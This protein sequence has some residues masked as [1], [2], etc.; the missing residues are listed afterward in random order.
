[1]DRRRFLAWMGMTATSWEGMANPARDL[2]SELWAEDSVPQNP[3]PSSNERVLYLLTYD[4]GGLVLWGKEHFLQYLHSAIEWLKRYPSFKI[5]LDNEAWTYDEL[6]RIAPEVLE[7][8]R[9]YLKQYP[10]R[11]GIG[12]CTYGQP[13]AQFINEESN[14]RQIAY[15]LETDRRYFSIAPSIYLMSEHAMHSQIPQILNGFK[16]Q[17]AIMR[18]HYMMYGYNPAFDLP[19]GWWVGRDGSKIAAVP[20]YKGEGA[21]FGKT[22]IDNW[23]LTRYPSKE[24]QES[25]ADFKRKF[26]RIQPLLASRADDSGLRREELVREIEGEPGYQWILLEELRSLFPQPAEE[27][28]TAPD[29]FK[30]RM[31]WGYC[32]NEIWNQSREA[33]VAVLTA[34]RM[35]AA[36][37]WHGGESCEALLDQAWK[38]LLVAQHHDIQICGL[39]REARQFLSASLERSHEIQRR[40]MEY[41]ASRLKAD[42]VAQITVFNPN[43]W[44]R[45]QWVKTLLPLP[46]GTAKSLQVQREGKTIPSLV[47]SAERSSQE[48]IGDAQMAFW[49]DL[50]SFSFATFSV[51]ASDEYQPPGFPSCH[52]DPH[53]LQ[54][55]SPH[56]LLMLNPQGGISSLQNR[57]TGQ[58]VFSPGR[59]SSI[60]SG[61]ID[62]RVCESSGNWT[63]M[64]APHGSAWVVAREQGEIGGIPYAVDLTIYG[65]TPRLDYRVTLEFNN[66]K[67]GQLSE[68]PRDD[69][70]AFVHEEKLRFKTFPSLPPSAIGIRD[71][72]FTIVE[73]DAR[74][75]EGNY[76]TAVGDGKAGLAYFNRGTM[77]AVREPDGGFSLPLAFAMNYIWG[78]RMLYGSLSYEFALYP[79][80][81][82]WREAG[83]HRLALDYNFPCPVHAG[84]PGNGEAG[85]TADIFDSESTQILLTACHV[86]KGQILARFWEHQGVGGKLRLQVRRE[87]A[88]L[89]EVNLAGDPL[90]KI[91]A[92]VDFK[93]WQFRTFALELV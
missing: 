33:E 87:N 60:L 55:T 79:F 80:L 15:A 16:F 8:L 34:E 46:R 92:P 3:S 31:P 12:T 86:K 43:H 54:I 58:E 61:R 24:S 57:H 41:M 74:Y 17:G 47:L 39:L 83:L 62:G 21:E 67:I 28:K 89:T 26:G 76:W 19:I 71:L 50:P 51:L 25:P 27:M 59:R 30:V 11:F 69:K 53:Q 9:G 7:Q 6:A 42:G 81:G 2:N 29:D 37:H 56:W 70:S 22:P 93:P 88:A 13:L 82:S 48:K 52:C 23:I 72:P 44:P 10:G 85:F 64:P 36:A 1:M 45:R 14:I 38:N 32:G 91:T 49:A 20:T 35:D 75:V 78:T 4:H 18:T 5:G 66:Q 73:T 84:S 77:G 65:D 68:N 63:M 90:G 40:S